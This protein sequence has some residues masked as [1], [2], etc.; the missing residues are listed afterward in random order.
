MTRRNREVYTWF[1]ALG[2]GAFDFRNA[3]RIA[4]EHVAR[5]RGRAK[6]WREGTPGFEPGT[7]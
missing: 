2:P 5:A 6:E 4:T 7:C 1:A 3:W